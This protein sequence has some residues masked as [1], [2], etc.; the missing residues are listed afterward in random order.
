[1][2]GFVLIPFY[3][4]VLTTEDFGTADLITTT[5][6][7]LLPIFT[8]LISETAIRF[9][10]DQTEDRAQIYSI[11][12]YS[13]VISNVVSIAVLVFGSTLWQYRLPWKS[14]SFAKRKEMDHY[15]LPM[16]PNTISWRLSSSA[17]K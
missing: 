15:C 4:A 8:L 5:V 11:G 9:A 16:I 17:N 12:L 1:M 2:F 3:T 6:S 14:I 10:L 7:L 13:Y